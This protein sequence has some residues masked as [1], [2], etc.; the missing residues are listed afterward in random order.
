MKASIL[1]FACAAALF[2]Q[3]R[4]DFSG[5][6]RLNREQSRYPNPAGMPAKLLKIVELKGDVLHYIIERDL[7]GD[8]KIERTDVEVEIGEGSDD[9]SVTARWDNRTL[10]VTLVTQTGFRQI[11]HW[12]LDASGRRLTD[13]TVV[14]R[15]D[16]SED[17]VLRVYDKE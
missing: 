5:T 6:W 10:V 4:P 2:A 8:G 14:R 7:K 13:R 12:E 15:P 11:E 3:A 16:G 1:A 17:T 9:S